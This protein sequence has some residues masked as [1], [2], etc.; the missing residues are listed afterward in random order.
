[1]GYERPR[2]VEQPQAVQ[3]PRGS[4]FAA[5]SIA[6]MFQEGNQD[7]VIAGELADTKLSA[8]TICK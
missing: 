6:L 5:A 4:S 1:M 8:D 3:Y 7:T 2:L